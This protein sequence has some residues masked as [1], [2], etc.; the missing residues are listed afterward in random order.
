M[1]MCAWLIEKSTEETHYKREECDDGYIFWVQPGGQK[2]GDQ[3]FESFVGFSAD[4]KYSRSSKIS[5]ENRA[6]DKSLWT[7]VTTTT[8][9][10]VAQF[11]G[12]RAMHSSVILAQLV[13]TLIMAIIRA[14]LRTQRMEKK[15][16]LIASSS[17]SR[18]FMQ[19]HE[20]DFLA[21]H[22]EDI[23]DMFV[24]KTQGERILEGM[25]DNYS[26]WL[27]RKTHIYRFPSG[28]TSDQSQSSACYTHWWYGC[29]CL[30]WSSH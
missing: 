14:G 21:L 6:V 4:L 22:L 18:D 2:I 7:A 9:G 5:R 26:P 20:L 13:S 16:D 23:D 17:K 11:V 3:V 27:T 29:P 15:L 19:G 24:S 10:F 30:G 8:I 1:F 25:S 12:L 28:Y